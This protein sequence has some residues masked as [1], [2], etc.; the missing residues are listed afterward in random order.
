MV[1]TKGQGYHNAT[2]MQR[3]S[4]SWA[5]PF[6]DFILKEKEVSIT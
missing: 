6:Y 1:F 4:Q 5:K 2:L 3:L